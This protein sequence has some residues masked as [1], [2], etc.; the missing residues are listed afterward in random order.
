M[1]RE[2]PNIDGILNVVSLLEKNPEDSVSLRLSDGHD[3]HPR[4]PLVSAVI[5]AV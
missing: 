1:N 4:S 2:A 5:A 3:V